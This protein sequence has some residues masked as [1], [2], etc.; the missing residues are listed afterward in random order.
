MEIAFDGLECFTESVPSTVCYVTDGDVISI[1]APWDGDDGLLYD[2][3][4][5]LWYMRL[6]WWLCSRSA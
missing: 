2:D 5:R 4:P 6:W 3:R 1:V